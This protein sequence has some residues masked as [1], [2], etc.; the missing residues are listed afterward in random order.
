M[1]LRQIFIPEVSFERGKFPLQDY[2][3]P[4]LRKKIF[5]VKVKILGLA[6]I[7]MNIIITAK[8]KARRQLPPLP[9]RSYAPVYWQYWQY[10]RSCA[11]LQVDSVTTLERQTVV[12]KETVMSLTSLWHIAVNPPLGKTVRDPTVDEWLGMV[13]P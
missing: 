7:I 3:H 10:W 5:K 9:Q 11:C 6:V 8:K 13:Q 1:L 4:Y 12:N 2:I